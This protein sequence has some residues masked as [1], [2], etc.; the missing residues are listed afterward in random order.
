M[1][2]VQT[3][4]LPISIGVIGGNESMLNFM[5]KGI[6]DP[7]ALA[8]TEKVLLYMKDKTVEFQKETGN[9]YNLEAV[10]GEGAMYSLALKD[11]KEHPDIIVAGKDKVFLNNATLPSVKE[12]N[13]I[14]LIKNQEYLQTIYT[15]GTTLNIYLGERLV[16]YKQAKR[17]VRKVIENTRIPYF[18]ITPTYSICKNHRYIAGEVDT[19]PVCKAKTDTYTRVVGYLKPMSRFN[20]GKVE[21][22]KN[23]KY[24]DVSDVDKLGDVDENK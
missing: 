9:L 10:P 18:S 20:E 19:C 7:E 17:L 8:F 6:M 2:G 16:D 23:R 12:G 22:F 14:N 13:F 21:E 24:Y 1:T 4:A 3:C 11:K 5:G 15:G